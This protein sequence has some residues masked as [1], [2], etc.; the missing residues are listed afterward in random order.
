MENPDKDLPIGRKLFEEIDKPVDS[1]IVLENKEEG[2]TERESTWT[3]DIKGYDNNSF[4]SW[5]AIGSGRSF[6]HD[7]NNGIIISHWQGQFKTEGKQEE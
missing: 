3:A 7:N 6:I 4:P 2:I 5:K 1:K